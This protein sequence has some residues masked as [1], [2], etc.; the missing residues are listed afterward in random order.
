[1][2]ILR[3]KEIRDMPSKERTKRIGELRTELLRLK[4]MV[5]AGGTI[6]NPAKI[7]ELRKAIARVLTI[8][9]EEELGLVKAKKTEKKR[10]KKKK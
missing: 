6:E 10:E 2:P 3:V 8:E 4:T 1:M 7:K 5:R 9:K